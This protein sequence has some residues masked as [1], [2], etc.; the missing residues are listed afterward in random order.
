MHVGLGSVR[1]MWC[2]AG[3]PLYMFYCREPHR[4]LVLPQGK[5]KHVSQQPT[6]CTCGFQE[7]TRGSVATV[8][9]FYLCSARGTS[10]VSRDAKQGTL[11]KQEKDDFFLREPDSYCSIKLCRNTSPSFER[12]SCNTGNTSM[13]ALSLGMLCLCPPYVQIGYK[14][15]GL[16]HYIGLADTLSETATEYRG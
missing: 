7:Y 8:Y 4:H 5:A 1:C 14:I 12:A 13:L 16:Q 2:S 10:L 3:I 15:S 9:Y 6:K 11:F